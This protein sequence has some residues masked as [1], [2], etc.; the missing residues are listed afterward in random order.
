MQRFPKI[1]MIVR[2]MAGNDHLEESSDCEPMQFSP[3]HKIQD[4]VRHLRDR[5]QLTRLETIVICKGAEMLREDTLLGT[6]A[7]ATGD[8]EVSLAR[9]DTKPLWR[10]KQAALARAR[11][12]AEEGEWGAWSRELSEEDRWEAEEFECMPSS[13]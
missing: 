6:L 2:G 5:L 11:L 8:V 1:R 9:F 4:V 13:M 7:D 3:V 12:H 10:M